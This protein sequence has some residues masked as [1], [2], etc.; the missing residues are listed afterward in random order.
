M[1]HK[2]FMSFN[3][4]IVNLYTVENG[5]CAGDAVQE[6]LT[7]F[8]KYRFK[9]KTVGASRYYIAMQNAV[10]IKRAVCIPTT[11]MQISTQMVAV[12]N[13]VQYNIVQVQLI[14]DTRPN[15]LILTLSEVVEKYDFAGI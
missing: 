12:I 2:E 10:E 13:D 4:G 11:D 9:N 8:G 5:A 1:K 14:Q 6:Q 7:F 3:D 15:H